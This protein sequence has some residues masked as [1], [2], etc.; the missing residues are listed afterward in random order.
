MCVVPSIIVLMITALIVFH[1]EL[2]TS[3]AASNSKTA[4]G[5]GQDGCSFKQ[6]PCSPKALQADGVV[7]GD[8]LI[9]RDLVTVRRL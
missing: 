2:T 8:G 6:P 7:R 1:R 9:D 4:H 5:T 3:W